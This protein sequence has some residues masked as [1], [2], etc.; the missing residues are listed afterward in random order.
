MGFDA[1]SKAS[2]GCGEGQPG[3]MVFSPLP[4]VTEPLDGALPASIH[5]GWE[6]KLAAHPLTTN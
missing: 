4:F 3:Q 6:R 5:Q 2:M 1:Q